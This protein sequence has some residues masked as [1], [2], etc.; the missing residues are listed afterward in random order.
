MHNQRTDAQLLTS[1]EVV[2]R[3]RDQIT[4]KT[5]SN[6]RSAGQGPAY[7]KIG[8]RVLYPVADLERWEQERRIRTA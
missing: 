2:R 8:G 4:V 3:Y 5:L 6:W 1:D 7:V